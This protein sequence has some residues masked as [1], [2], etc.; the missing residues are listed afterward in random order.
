MYSAD[1]WCPSCASPKLGF[2]HTGAL[3]CIIE[4]PCSL[5]RGYA[6]HCPCDF[7]TPPW[8][9][10]Y[11]ETAPAMGP[12]DGDRSGNTPR[13]LLVVP[14]ASPSS[15]FGTHSSCVLAEFGL[16]LSRTGAAGG[17]QRVHAAGSCSRVVAGRVLAGRTLWLAG[18][19]HFGERRSQP[20]S[21]LCE[22]TPD[23]L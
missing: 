12:R 8:V 14:S 19:L 15:F 21:R 6:S 16:P 20:V 9:F 7:E 4:C 5:S 23:S 18:N 10:R 13:C 22:Q 11:P 3:Q 2:T 1:A 17:L